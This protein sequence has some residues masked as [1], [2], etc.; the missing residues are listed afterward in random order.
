MQAENKGIASA[1]VKQTNADASN[2]LHWVGLL[3]KQQCCW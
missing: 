3:M 2:Q 1:H